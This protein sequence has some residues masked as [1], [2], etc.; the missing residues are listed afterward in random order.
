VRCGSTE[1]LQ[2]HHRV[3]L[4]T[5]PE[6]A[7]VEIYAW[8]RPR[9]VK[10]GDSGCWHHLDGLETLC[11][12]CH[13]DEHH[14]EPP[15]DPQLRLDGALPAVSCCAAPDGK[16]DPESARQMREANIEHDMEA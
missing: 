11:G 6:T 2:V 1:A 10:H 13:H 12:V 4:H 15:P 9:K 16:D 3:A 14:P 8:R 7:I 5:L